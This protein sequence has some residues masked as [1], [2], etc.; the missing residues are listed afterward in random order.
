MKRRIALNDGGLVVA[1]TCTKCELELDIDCFHRRPDGSGRASH[2][3]D[4]RNSS[5]RRRYTRHSSDV[6]SRTTKYKN[7][8]SIKIIEILKCSSCVDC[9]R[10]DFRVLEFDHLRDKRFGIG[11]GAFSRSWDA[12]SIEMEKCEV[13]CR[14]CHRRRTAIRSNNYKVSEI[15]PTRVGQRHV[16]EYL[17]SNPCISCGESDPTMLEFHH[18]HGDGKVGAI[19]FLVNRKRP[20]SVIEDEI[21]KCAVLCA[22][23]HQI[24][25]LSEQGWKFRSLQDT[26]RITPP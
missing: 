21:G 19:A 2:C 17:S 3:K 10:D 11:R 12:I 18:L 6:C 26:G 16:I 20:L 24:E 1:K 5:N 13:V 7:A 23:C 22:N 25:T 4:C 14:N 15:P 9:G 8:K